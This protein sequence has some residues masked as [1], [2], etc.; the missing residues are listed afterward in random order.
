[1]TLTGVGAGLDKSENQS[2]DPKL[3]RLESLKA[4]LIEQGFDCFQSDVGG[5]GES[6]VLIIYTYEVQK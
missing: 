2:D 6:E 3:E 5:R 1:M 4:T